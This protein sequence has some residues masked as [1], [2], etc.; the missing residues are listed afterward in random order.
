MN[1]RTI[2]FVALGLILAVLWFWSGM[3][4]GK[5]EVT[6]VNTRAVSLYFGAA[7]SEL[8]VREQRAVSPE[9]VG[10]PYVTELLLAGPTTSEYLSVIPPGTK[11][12]DW[13]MQNDTLTLDFSGE[14][15]DGHPGGS[16]A[17]LQTVFSIVNTMTELPGV[18]RVQLLIAGRNVDT[19][20]GHVDLSVPL[21]F[22]AEMVEAGTTQ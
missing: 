14:L 2:G 13:N 12:L 15:A 1:R 9:E 18:K 19:L 11:L 10:V 21:E 16:S 4:S 20:V 3:H 6:G 5:S 22:A 17:E 7:T 8:L